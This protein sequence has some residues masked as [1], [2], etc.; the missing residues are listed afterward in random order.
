MK[1]EVLGECLVFCRGK[2]R[3]GEAGLFFLKKHMVCG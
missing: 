1:D 2:D 3:E